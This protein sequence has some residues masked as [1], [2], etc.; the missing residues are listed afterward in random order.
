MWKKLS[1]IISLLRPH[2]WLKNLL[3]LF[4][5]FFGKKMGSADVLA[6]IVPSLISFSLAASSVYI[7]NDIMDRESDKHHPDKRNRAIASGNLSITAALIIAVGVGLASLL[8]AAM[9]SRAFEA[10]L[11]LYILISFLYTIYFK[12]I[13]IIELFIVSFGFLL[14]ILAGGEAFHVVVSNWLFLTVFVSAL[15]LTAGKRLGELIALSEKAG[16]HRM[17]LTGYT[18]SYLEG[19]LWFSTAVALVMYALYTL[20]HH[21]GLFYTVPVI[22][23]GMLR[24]VFLVKQGTGDPTVVLMQDLHIQAAGVI[25]IAMAWLMVYVR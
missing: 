17:S 1:T 6:A 5:P 10:Y 24:Y 3:I 4:P 7:V 8:L 16:N 11:I 13:I 18:V 23:Y 19:I 9:V 22:T 15:F 20:E 14:R 12:H 21:N 2:Q 25:W